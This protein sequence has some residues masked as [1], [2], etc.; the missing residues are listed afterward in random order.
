MIIKPNIAIIRKQFVTDGVC[1]I[2]STHRGRQANEVFCIFRGSASGSYSSVRQEWSIDYEPSLYT[3]NQT[4]DATKEEFAEH[5][6]KNYPDDFR[7]MLFHP[8]IFEGFYY[9]G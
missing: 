4:K 7:W 9:D 6:A 1:I 2:P 5:I 8:E 3:V